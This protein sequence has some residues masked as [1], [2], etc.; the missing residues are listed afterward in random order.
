MSYGLNCRHEIEMHGENL[1]SIVGQRDEV[2]Y[3]YCKAA[4]DNV[5]L[6][7]TTRNRLEMHGI[8]L[9]NMKAMNRLIAF[10]GK[11]SLGR[12]V[13]RLVACK[14]AVLFW[15]INLCQ[16]ISIP[17]RGMFFGLNLPTPWYFPV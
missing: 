16:K 8:F 11:I 9:F 15:E 14:Q 3:Y 13:D 10:G 12:S 6:T 7:K 5:F 4:C 1:N 17:P 2:G